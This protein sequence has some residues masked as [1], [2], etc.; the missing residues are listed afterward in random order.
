MRGL[1]ELQNKHHSSSTAAGLGAFGAF[2][3]GI[4]LPFVPFIGC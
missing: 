3:K 4:L 1:K 2:F